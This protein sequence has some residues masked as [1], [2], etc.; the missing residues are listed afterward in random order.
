MESAE[1][2]C[3]PLDMV[4]AAEPVLGK[5]VQLR[6]DAGVVVVFGTGRGLA[7]HNQILARFLAD[8]GVPHRW[9]TVERL[10]FDRRVEVF[11]GGRFRLDMT[12]GALDVWDNSSVFGR[13]CER[14]LPW[15]LRSAAPPWNR[16]RLEIR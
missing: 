8:R 4:D 2:A 9:P 1:V 3:Y 10:E 7:Y 15:Q 5:F 16:L 11:G 12:N 6:I 14:D 13:F